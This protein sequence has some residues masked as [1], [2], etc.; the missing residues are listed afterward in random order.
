MRRLFAAAVAAIFLTMPVVIGHTADAAG[1]KSHAERK[2]E[3][4]KSIREVRERIDRHGKLT[5]EEKARLHGYASTIESE[6]AAIDKAT[7]R[8]LA[9]T[10]G[11]A[12]VTP[13]QKAEIEAE[14]RDHL[15]RIGASHAKLGALQ[16]EM[17]TEVQASP[18]LSPKRKAELLAVVQKLG[19]KGITPEE[20][21]AA[22]R[23]A[24]GDVILTIELFVLMVIIG[25]G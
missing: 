5:A 13:E 25:A 23:G 19:E 22:V 11:G 8:V 1:G 9:L 17:T 10:A 24:D 15:T 6:T 20:A 4:D 7:E 16:R 14:V 3:R 12:S 18:E 2:A 21:I